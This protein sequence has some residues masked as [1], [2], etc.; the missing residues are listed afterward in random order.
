[1]VIEL[2]EGKA[3]TF[4]LEN[5]EHTGLPFRANLYKDYEAVGDGI[6]WAL[7]QGACIKSFYSKDDIKENKRLNELTPIKDGETVVINKE[8]YKVVI[9][10][11][12]SD[13]AVFKKL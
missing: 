11:N 13:C 4:T 1:M 9:N 3:N 10:G 5:K 8:K 6:Y 12:Y 7:Q 2:K